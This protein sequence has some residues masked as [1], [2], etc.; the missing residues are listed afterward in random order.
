[1]WKLNLLSDSK[2][3][4]V[5]RLRQ[6]EV[7]HAKEIGV[8]FYVTEHFRGRSTW[9]RGEREVIAR[10][11]IRNCWQLKLMCNF[12]SVYLVPSMLTNV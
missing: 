12:Y 5:I 6:K 11:R 4:D 9:S 8:R 2:T 3:Q 7:G 1:M 10:L